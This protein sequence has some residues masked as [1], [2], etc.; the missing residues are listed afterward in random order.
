MSW[1]TYGEEWKCYE[2][3]AS[4]VENRVGGE[5]LSE[6]TIVDSENRVEGGWKLYSNNNNSGSRAVDAR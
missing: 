1:M 4:R 5:N 6:G 2:G 3:T